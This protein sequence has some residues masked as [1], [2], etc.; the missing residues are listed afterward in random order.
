MFSETQMAATYYYLY[1]YLITLSVWTAKFL[2]HRVSVKTSLSKFQQIFHL[3]KMAAIFNF[4]NRSRWSNFDEL[5]DP[6]D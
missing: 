1:F 5:I 2:T 6:Q 4:Q 3:P